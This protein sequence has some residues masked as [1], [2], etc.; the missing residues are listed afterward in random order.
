M[1]ILSRII[2]K[3]KVEIEDLKNSV[4]IADLEKSN[5]FN[6]KTKSLS[7][8]IKQ[9]EIGII[10]EHKR[11]SPSKSNIN[12]QN[13]SKSII[14]G[15]DDGGAAGIS[16]LTE[17]NFF[18][19]SSYE[20]TEARRLTN[21]PML[22]KDFIID[23]YQVIESKSIG[24]DAILLIAA[25]LNSSEI[26]NLSKLAKSFDLEV[27]IEIHDLE[28]L[29]KS[30]IDSIDIIGVNNR[31]LKTFNVNIETSLNLVDKIPSSFTKISESGLNNSYEIKK[32]KN[33]GFDGFLIGERFMKSSNPGEELSNFIS[34]IKNES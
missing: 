19:G 21:L 8:N 24:A 25:C 5:L 33:S 31:N 26:I 18:D 17:K 20:F 10:A 28:E 7:D 32:L 9:K 29:N 22:R 23:E 27:L 6:T 13:S 3:K 4:S 16:F 1:D 11:K 30:C 14:N 34:K 15:Y 2:K 12:H